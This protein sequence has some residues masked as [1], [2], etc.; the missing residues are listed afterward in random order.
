MLTEAIAQDL[1]PVSEHFSATV[2]FSVNWTMYLDG[3]VRRAYH[4]ESELCAICNISGYPAKHNS[5]VVQGTVPHINNG[6][7]QNSTGA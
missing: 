6:S 3:H 2:L 1:S 5:G 4:L 7:N